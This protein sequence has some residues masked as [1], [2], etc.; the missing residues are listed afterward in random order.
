MGAFFAEMLVE[1]FLLSPSPPDRL[2][3]NAPYFKRL[4]KTEAKRHGRK[5][6]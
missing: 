3:F 6:R 1:V 4:S 5:D 2:L